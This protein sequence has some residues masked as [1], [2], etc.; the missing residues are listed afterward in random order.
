MNITTI[1][2]KID[3]DL[4]LNNTLSH[5]D[6][7]EYAKM[8]KLLDLDSSGIIKS[9]I[10]KFEDD[11][12]DLKYKQIDLKYLNSHLFT[13][14]DDSSLL[15]KIKFLESIMTPMDERD[16]SIKRVSY[17]VHRYK[18]FDFNDYHN[19]YKY[20]FRLIDKLLESIE[21]GLRHIFYS[22]DLILNCNAIIKYLKTINDAEENQVPINYT[23]DELRTLW[24]YF[25]LLDK[26]T[27]DEYKKYEK[28]PIEEVYKIIND[29]FKPII[30]DSFFKFNSM[31]EHINFNLKVEKIYNISA[32]YIDHLFNTLNED[33]KIES[34]LFDVLINLNSV[35]YELES[36]CNSENVH[37]KLK[38]ICCDKIYDLFGQLLLVILKK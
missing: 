18:S 12:Y 20:I 19:K 33:E 31:E 32:I 4:Y 24:K 3:M 21:Y 35:I 8:L 9:W 2:N 5:E 37:L 15:D 30:F 6:F 23:Y 26:T 11:T 34:K 16:I 14:K 25:L 22:Y 10:A 38:Y 7:H 1:R 13:Y 29:E 28:M 27:Y 17:F 36:Y